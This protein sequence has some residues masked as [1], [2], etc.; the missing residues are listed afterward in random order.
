MQLNQSDAG[1]NS[2]GQA[3]LRQTEPAPNSQTANQGTID[4]VQSLNAGNSL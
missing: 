2:L 3:I 1:L 4:L